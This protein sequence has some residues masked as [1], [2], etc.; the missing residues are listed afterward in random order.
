MDVSDQTRLSQNI[1]Q[2][3]GRPHMESES[4]DREC[5]RQRLE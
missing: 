2:P 3:G 5:Y 4:E 1:L